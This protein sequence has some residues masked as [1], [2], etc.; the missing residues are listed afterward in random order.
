MATSPSAIEEIDAQALPLSRRTSA[1]CH[2]EPNTAAAAREEDSKQSNLGDKHKSSSSD[3]NVT[4][5]TTKVAAFRGVFAPE[6]APVRRAYLVLIARALILNLI[7]MWICLPVFWGA[8]ADSPKLTRN[9]KA[10][11]I[12]R[13]GSRIGQ[14]LLE[15]FC[16]NTLPDPQLGWVAV[17]PTVVEDDETISQLILAGRAWVAVVIEANA[18]TRLINARA[19][20]DMTYNPATA[21]TVYYAQARNEVAIGNYV[22]PIITNLLQYA[23]SAYATSTAQRYF[24][25]INAEDKAN[26]TAIEMLARAPQTI[27]PAISWTVVNLRP[28]NVPTAQA[29]TLVGNIFL[30]I[31]AFLITM[32]HATGRELIKPHLPFRSYI[33][34]RII[35]PFTVYFPLSMSYSLVSLAFD[36]PFG[37]RFTE[38]SG[39][40]LFF[41]FV[42]LGMTALGLSLESMITI[43]TPRF[44]PFFLFVLIIFNIAPV[45]MPH[46]LQ[47]PFYMYGIGFPIWNL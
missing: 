19:N 24:A 40:M 8:L 36:I 25:Q 37:N 17:D 44:V 6:L 14:A 5:E 10:W 12:D 22:V 7:L 20:G 30:C 28:Y 41:V 34:I 38:G 18:T 11:Y 33:I 21:I 23:T 43:L 3:E 35:V 15:V 42:Y 45:I 31:F 13:D 26:E 39:F 4:V 9:L 29:I 1:G 2:A 47:H 16:N 27:S 32:A 46:E